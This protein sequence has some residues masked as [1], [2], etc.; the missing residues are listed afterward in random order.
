MATKLSALISRVQ[1]L[2]DGRFN[3]CCDKWLSLRFL[4]LELKKLNFSRDLC[5]I[6]TYITDS[7][8]N[9]FEFGNSCNDFIKKTSGEEQKESRYHFS[10]WI[11]QWCYISVMVPRFACNKKSL[12]DCLFMVRAERTPKVPHYWPLASGIHRGL[13]DS[14]SQRVSVPESF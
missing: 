5:I 4:S 6:V 1:W 11:L 9:V 3:I 12:F 13:V 7:W 14:S 2:M 10:T 8:D